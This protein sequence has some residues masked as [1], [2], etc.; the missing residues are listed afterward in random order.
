VTSKQCRRA[1]AYQARSNA[2]FAREEVGCELERLAK[3]RLN[4]ARRHRH[5]SGSLRLGGTSSA[6]STSQD[7]IARQNTAYPD[8]IRSGCCPG[9]RRSADVQ[10]R[11][12]PRRSPAGGCGQRRIS[13]RRTGLRAA[14]GSGSHRWRPGCRPVAGVP[15]SSQPDQVTL[16]ACPDAGLEIC[17]RDQVHP[18]V[19]DGL[20]VG[21][22]PAEPEQAQPERQVREQVHTLT[23]SAPARARRP[24]VI[25]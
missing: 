16:D 20:Q 18:G 9:S 23:A 25:G 17:C 12:R 4:Q 1:D 2:T 19:E 5:A 21:L 7:C 14:G 11:S 24:R 13:V 3:S 8:P 22:G 15:G 6:S 10:A